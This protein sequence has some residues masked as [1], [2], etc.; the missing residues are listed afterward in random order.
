MESV[1]IGEKRQALKT[2]VDAV[3]VRY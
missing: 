2:Y 3:Y 1:Q